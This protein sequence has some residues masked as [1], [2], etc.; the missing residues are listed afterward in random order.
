MGKM[1]GD[2]KSEGAEMKQELNKMKKSMGFT[3]EADIDDR[4]ATI[5]FKLWTESISLKDE[6]NYMAEIKELKKNRPKVSQVSQMQDKVSNFDAG[7]DLREKRKE[8]NELV[9]IE[10]EKK[11][12]IQERLT[13]LTESRKAQMGDVQPTLDKRDA[14]TKKVQELI[15]ER[16][17]L[18]DEFNEEKRA[19]QSYL[20]EQR[21]AKQERYQQERKEQQEQ[22]KIKQLE[23]QI[24]NLDEQPFVS[25]ITLIEQTI[26]FCQGLMPQDSAGQKKEEKETVYN[27]KDGE[28]VLL[29]KE[30]RADEWFYAPTKTA[31]SKKKGKAA[32]ADTSKKPIK[33]NAETFK[34]FDSLKLDAPITVADIPPLLEK[35]NAQMAEYQAKVKDWRENKEAM[36]RKIL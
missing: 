29:K 16:T 23:K 31:K 17:K 19:F 26:K 13:E 33:H 7:T 1:L 10:R 28:T 5:E 15:A 27:N 24:E 22:W 6:K 12:G 4:I 18:R 25:E 36:K 3:S 35:L 34:L 20:A 30:I 11:K 9:A 2:K 14:L 8:L 32:D 21:R